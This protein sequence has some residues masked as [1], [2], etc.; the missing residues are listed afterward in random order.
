MKCIVL[1]AGKGTRMLPLT[2]DIP[3]HLI[4]VGGKPF[5]THFLDILKKAG[6]KEKDIGIVV[7]YKGEMIRKF[8]E[9]KKFMGKVIDQG[10]PLGTGHA[11]LKAK[12]FV[13]N[14]NFVV[15]NGDSIFSKE[16]LEN[17]RKDDEYCYL[18]AD[19]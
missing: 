1:A 2:E 8:L 10:E 4:N 17:I 13:K 3:K 15:I 6:Y 5:L 9:N 11:V 16:D 14:G 18:T 7:S 19:P 12:E